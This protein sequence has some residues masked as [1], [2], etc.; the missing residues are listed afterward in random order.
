VAASVEAEAATASTTVSGKDGRFYII[1]GGY[2]RMLNAEFSRQEIAEL[3]HEAKVLEPGKGSRL[4]K[5]SVAN[6]ATAEEAQAAMNT[7]RQTFGETIWVF[8]N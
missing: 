8:N 4:F 1:T 7:Y 5:V 2:A 6:F 3:G